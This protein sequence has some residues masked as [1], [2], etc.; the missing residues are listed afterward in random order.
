[1]T[2]PSV[3][4][5]LFSGQNIKSLKHDEY[6]ELLDKTG[7]A[8]RSLIR[9][10]LKDMYGKNLKHFIIKSW[11]PE[12]PIFNN[13]YYVG[14]LDLFSNISAV[15]DFHFSDKLTKEFTDEFKVIFEFKPKIESFSEVIRQIK[16]YQ[17][18]VKTNSQDH[19]ITFCL[20]ESDI[21][22]FK[23]L[24]K[25]QGIILINIVDYILCLPPDYIQN[26]EKAHA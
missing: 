8:F 22:Q 7:I 1:M 25:D 11:K 13:F 23:D 15:R 12:E 2:A 4:P 26:K 9:D 24:F 5:K 19:L 21:S 3:Q 16:V 20:T 17:K 14:S 6:L 18:L 10:A